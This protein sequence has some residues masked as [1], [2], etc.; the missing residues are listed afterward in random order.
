[1]KF[2]KG[3]PRDLLYNIIPETRNLSIIDDTMGKKNGH[4]STCVYEKV[5]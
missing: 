2:I 3:W 5:I 4:M 1:M